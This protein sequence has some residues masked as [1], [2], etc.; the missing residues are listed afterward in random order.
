MRPWALFFGLVL[1]P[2][3][4]FGA[5]PGL[6][7][8]FVGFYGL[9][10]D[11]P[12]AVS[13]ID[14][15]YQKLLELP[16]NPNSR[17]RVLEAIEQGRDPF[18]IPGEDT[19]LYTV[20]KH[21]QEFRRMLDRLGWN[22][23]ET[24][25]RLLAQVAQRLG[26][27]EMAVKVRD[28]S[29]K[30]GESD[31]RFQFHNAEHSV[32]MPG[33]R[34]YI[35]RGN[36][37]APDYSNRIYVYDTQTKTEM[38]V[39][40]YRTGVVYRPLPLADGKRVVIQV[41]DQLKI[42]RFE[43]GKISA[44]AETINP[45][46]LVG[47]VLGRK[48]RQLELITPLKDDN[49]IVAQLQDTHKLVLY[50]LEKKTV[51]TIKGTGPFI[52]GFKSEE[53]HSWGLV[54]AT[55]ELLVLNPKKN[56]LVIRSGILGAKGQVE[57]WKTVM[58]FPPRPEDQRF[59]GPIQASEQYIILRGI[60]KPGQVSLINRKDG[61]VRDLATLH[62]NGARVDYQL[63]PDGRRALTYSYD[64]ESRQNSYHWMDLDSGKTTFILKAK[65]DAHLSADGERLI[66]RG[67]VFDAGSRDGVVIIVN[68][69]NRTV[70]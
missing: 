18:A 41:G 39:P 53:N 58:E 67:S 61:T 55:N 42:H 59:Y 64:A 24:R 26:R 1:A 14:S 20:A 10:S 68:P 44:D 56:R 66:F 45:L 69:H 50:D 46:S 21:T 54:K 62:P 27:T 12:Q 31:V 11:D 43:E 22:T 19:D 16:V 48:H 8:C 6:D 3:A 49:W 47:K 37:P 34:Y 15:T 17:E 23:P 5:A 9:A 4:G 57:E 13:L 28:Q 7:P 2:L 35:S 51:R 65:S 52:K 25:A 29:L 70:P 60:P 40:G 38:S 30:D 32:A 36:G 63:H 33:G